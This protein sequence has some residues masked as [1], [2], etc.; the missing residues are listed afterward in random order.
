MN[1]AT[2]T[3]GPAHPH[4]AAMTLEDG[5]VLMISKNRP[6]YVQYEGRR[7]AATP[8][9]IYAWKKLTGQAQKE[10]AARKQAAYARGVMRGRC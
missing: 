9:Q 4:K 7:V 10:E 2:K 1:L 8:A 6:A 3:L 5:G